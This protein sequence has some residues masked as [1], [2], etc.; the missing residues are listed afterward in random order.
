M[1]FFNV[2]RVLK[3]VSSLVCLVFSGCLECL[4]CQ[5]FKVLLVC[6]HSPVLSSVAVFNVCRVLKRVSSLVCLV[7]SGCLQCLPCLEACV[8]TCLSCLEWLSSM[9]A[10]FF[11]CVFTRLSRLQWLSSM[12]ECRLLVCVVTVCMRVGQFITGRLFLLCLS[13]FSVSACLWS[14]CQLCVFGVS[15]SLPCLSVCLHRV[16]TMSL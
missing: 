12:P 16:L 1:A 15:V 7:L 2:C 10:V 11:A 4:P 6:L 9:S 8:F 13:V 5:G 14:M 3:R